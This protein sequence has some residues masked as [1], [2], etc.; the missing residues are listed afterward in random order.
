MFLYYAHAFGDGGL[1]WWSDL[2][3]EGKQEA[4]LDP[5]SNIRRMYVRDTIKSV[6]PA[7]PPDRAFMGIGWAAFHS[8]I[9]NPENDL[10]LLFKSSPYGSASHSHSDQNS[11]AI[12]KGGKAMA[13]PAGARYPQHGSPFHRQY[14]R[15]TM[16]H[17]A[18]LI[19]GKGQLDRDH[20]AFGELSDFKSLPHIGYATGDAK[21][22]Y[23]P[24]VTRY[25]RHAIFIRPSLIII[26]DEL[27]SEEP[28]TIDWLLHGKE[29]FR[30][31]E[32]NQQLTSVRGNV[33]MDITLLAEGEFEF[34]QTDEWPMDPKQDYPMVP[35][36]PPAKQ[37][38]FTGH[39][40]KPASQTVIA[41]LMSIENGSEGTRLETIQQDDG[42]TI[43]ISTRFAG[44]NMA[45]IQLNLGTDP[46]SK[47]RPRI[48]I[49]YHPEEGDMEEII[50]PSLK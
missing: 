33:N 12:M 31:D 30:L 35:E 2:F 22:A 1:R 24:P 17:N 25:L 13:I 28:V 15:L 16:A 45:D 29:K 47:S 18:L 23:G 50:I 27:E 8:D 32:K 20:L 40:R 6:R 7:L 10:M 49:I 19:N 14:N 11:F 21:L 39:L 3:E 4:G 41:A 26:V 43:A 42:K 36:A 44:G 46:E 37:W 5:L 34:S 9:T 48:K 38:H